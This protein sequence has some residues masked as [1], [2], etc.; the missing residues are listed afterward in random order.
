MLGR[1]PA[2]WLRPV[3]LTVWRLLLMRLLVRLL[4]RLLMRLH[5]LLVLLVLLLMLLMLLCCGWIGWLLAVRRLLVHL[6]G[7]VGV[8]VLGRKRVVRLLDMAMSL[9]RL[10]LLRRIA[11]LGRLWSV[12]VIGALVPVLLRRWRI[13]AVCRSLIAATAMP[14]TAAPRGVAAVYR[15]LIWL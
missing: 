5:V 15:R 13:E 7:V 12:V 14:A 4:V 10:P 11:R 2:L 9:L 8:V 1:R 6:R 3:L